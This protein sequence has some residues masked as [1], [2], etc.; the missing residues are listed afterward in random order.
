MEAYQ[1]GVAAILKHI[2]RSAEFCAGHKEYALPKGRKP[3]ASFDMMDFRLRVADILSGNV[4]APSLIP[5][6][7]PAPP[8]GTAPRRTL[9]RGDTGDLVRQLQ[10]RLQIK[11][12]GDF[13][14]KTEAALRAFQR[15]NGLVPD[16][17]AG[18]KTWRAL[19]RVIV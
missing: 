15:S 13:G 9:R 11:V 18:P 10:S 2:G 19:D 12:D 5:A 17:I 7:E 14:S 4:S 8:A 16:G 3:D 1:S 6:I